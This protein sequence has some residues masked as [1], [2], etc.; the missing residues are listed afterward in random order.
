G[1]SL[2]EILEKGDHW[3]EITH[4]YIQWLFPTTNTSTNAPNAPVLLRGKGKYFKTK[5][6]SALSRMFVFYNLRMEVELGGEANVVKV[7]NFKANYKWLEPSNHNA[8]RFT[9]II[10]SLRHFR[11]GVYANALQ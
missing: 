6:V 1:P 5:I 10:A 8:L 2:T 7:T 3:L 11:L 9:R 4:G